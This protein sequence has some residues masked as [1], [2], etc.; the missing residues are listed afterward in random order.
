MALQN[1]VS[2]QYFKQ[3]CNL[4]KAPSLLLP[5]QTQ[6]S[7]FT[8]LSSNLRLKASNKEVEVVFDDGE[9]K[10]NEDG[11]ELMNEEERKEWRK[12]IREVMDKN[13]Q[14]NEQMDVNERKKIMEK[15]IAEYPLVVNEEDPSW[16]EDADGWG[17]NLGQ[18][19]D[20]ISIKN[21]KK[22][23]DNDEGYD[24]DKELVWQD[25]DYIRPIKEISTKEWEETV[26][27]DI[28]PLV[29]FVHNRYRRPKE[30]EM[31]REELEKVAHIF[32][33]CGLPSPRCVAVDAVVELDLVSALK[34]SV[35]PEVLFAK[36]GRILYREKV[37][38]SADELSKIMG[39][40]YYGAAKPP[41]LYTVG[42][43]QEMIPSV[44]INSG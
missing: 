25:D 38:R 30:N 21:V 35:F 8:I 34:V 18:F 41:C 14:V 3:N 1:P 43:S 40:F 24:S 12:K 39:F 4:H 44:P 33:N 23:D 27:K 13:S 28:S 42:T 26:F 16:P 32:W 31:V 36:A 29:V 15:L 11:S 22:D 10:K 9:K 5:K 17:F 7:N 20:K 2:F 19:F 6:T 37:F